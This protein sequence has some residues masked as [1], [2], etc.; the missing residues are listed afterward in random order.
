MK[1]MNKSEQC[2]KGWKS[3]LRY[4]TIYLALLSINDQGLCLSADAAS[5]N[6]SKYIW[7]L[8]VLFF[9][10]LLF[11]LFLTHERWKKKTHGNSMSSHCKF[12]NYK[13]CTFNWLENLTSGLPSWYTG[14]ELVHNNY[15]QL[16]AKPSDAWENVI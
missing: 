14:R 15:Y 6:K 2:Q 11:F 13:L 1:L 12:V 5:L 8:L 7:L 16:V 10:Y 9:I 3:W 4:L